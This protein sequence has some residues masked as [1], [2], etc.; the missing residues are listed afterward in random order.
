ME[1]NEKKNSYKKTNSS[2]LINPEKD[3]I[4]ESTEMHVNFT[5]E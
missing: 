1:S 3:G 2:N 5:H 4:I